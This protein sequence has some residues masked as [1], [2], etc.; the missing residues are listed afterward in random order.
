[1]EDDDGNPITSSQPS[2][3][4]LSPER[5]VSAASVQSTITPVAMTEGMSRMQA[6]RLSMNLAD[7]GNDTRKVLL[8]GTE[9][10]QQQQQ[11]EEEERRQQQLES[12]TTKVAAAGSNSR[13]KGKKTEDPRMLLVRSHGVVVQI[14]TKY[15][16]RRR[17]TTTEKLKER[18]NEER[19]TDMPTS[20][21]AAPVGA[22]GDPQV[23]ESKSPKRRGSTLK[24]SSERR[25]F[26]IQPSAQRRMSRRASK[27]TGRANIA[28][29]LLSLETHVEQKPR[30]S[31]PETP[32]VFDDAL[33]QQIEAFFRSFRK[34]HGENNRIT[35]LQLMSWY[36][37]A[38]HPDVILKQ[39]GR[40]PK[41]VFESFLRDFK[42][43]HVSS[44]KHSTSHTEDSTEII[45]TSRDFVAFMELVVKALSLEALQKHYGTV[46]D[47][48]IK[49]WRPLTE[50]TVPV[51][52]PHSDEPGSPG[53]LLST[54]RDRGSGVP[55]VSP[56]MKSPMLV[57]PKVNESAPQ[58]EG[59]RPAN[60]RVETPT[61]EKRREE[62]LKAS[63]HTPT[64]HTPTTPI[65][66]NPEVLSMGEKKSPM[67]LFNEW[68]FSEHQDMSFPMKMVEH[69]MERTKLKEEWEQLN[70]DNG[71]VD[72]D[73]K[74]SV[75]EEEGEEINEPM[76]IETTDEP[77]NNKV[78][79]FDKRSQTLASEIKPS[80]QNSSAS[81]WKR[82]AGSPRRG[83]VLM[84][85]TLPRPKR[86][87]KRDIHNDTGGIIEEDEEENTTCDNSASSSSTSSS[88]TSHTSHISMPVAHEIGEKLFAG[89]KSFEGDERLVKV[90]IYEGMHKE[91]KAP[92]FICLKGECLSTGD[93]TRIL[94]YP[95]DWTASSFGDL[96]V[97]EMDKKELLA[98]WIFDN[99]TILPSNVGKGLVL[100]VDNVAR[101]EGTGRPNTPPGTN[102]PR[103]GTS[104]QELGAASPLL[105]NSPRTPARKGRRRM[106][107]FAGGSTSE[108]ER[109]VAHTLTKAYSDTTLDDKTWRELQVLRTDS[110]LRIEIERRRKLL[111]AA[112]SSTAD[113]AEDAVD[114]LIH[115]ATVR[116]NAKK[117]Y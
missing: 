93:V 35:I 4:L 88:S 63:L 42:V 59:S 99:L 102:S 84:A 100:G 25:R 9:Q 114:D 52:I 50:V 13:P 7:A 22:N 1:M 55:G 108:N 116:E 8:D 39:K 54:D 90:I 37:P 53:V 79:I 33:K 40:N 70:G 41:Q 19:V 21:N 75:Q 17:K 76:P 78:P 83:S 89:I 103:S 71:R 46:H 27:F 92:L 101:A 56:Y 47:L 68:H 18:K 2:S 30:P 111:T 115:S 31:T 72:V 82:A 11:E 104:K 24:I 112:Y 14:E 110:I 81:T 10:Q 29:K 61:L 3:L 117:H 16:P 26:T 113:T 109:S 97:L 28:S 48:L 66:V 12:E 64:L 73:D 67:Y 38:S 85:A 20:A 57:P 58:N 106:S 44:R 60:L 5:K 77:S 62:A 6:K 23:G 91:D 32:I 105:S 15:S 95:H 45:V 80:A 87:E 65:D 96:R 94:I 36:Y 74:S 43:S 34:Q 69:Q 51:L 107:T 49:L 98:K 86:I